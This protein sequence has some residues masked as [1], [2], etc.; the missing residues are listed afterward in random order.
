MIPGP[1][2]SHGPQLHSLLRL[3][4]ACEDGL[5]L[6]PSIRMPGPGVTADPKGQEE[7]ISFL[8]QAPPT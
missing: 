8:L 3:V 5:G 7:L 4:A 2:L 6:P 1:G